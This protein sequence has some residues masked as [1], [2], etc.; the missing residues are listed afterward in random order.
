MIFQVPSV[1]LEAFGDSSL[2][3]AAALILMADED[4]VYE[5]FAL[6][7]RDL[8]AAQVR[9]YLGLTVN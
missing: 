3:L 4:G 9:E 6:H 2:A 7:P 8:S 1:C 5:R